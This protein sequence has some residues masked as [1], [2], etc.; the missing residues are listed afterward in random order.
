MMQDDIYNFEGI[1][2]YNHAALKE[3][4]NKSMYVFIQT[5]SGIKGVDNNYENSEHLE[6]LAYICEDGRKIYP[7]KVKL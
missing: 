6:K 3:L 5:E 7:L 4:E 2:A 1:S